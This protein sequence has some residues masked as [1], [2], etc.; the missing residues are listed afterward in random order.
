MKLNTHNVFLGNVDSRSVIKED[1]VGY[2]FDFQ[3]NVF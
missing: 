2:A 3:M 1:K